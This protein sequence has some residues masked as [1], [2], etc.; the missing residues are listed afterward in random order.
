MVVIEQVAP[1]SIGRELDLEAGDMLLKVNDQPVEDCLDA[2]FWLAEESVLLEIQKANGELWELAVDKEVADDLGLAFE[3]PQPRSCGNQCIFCF[4]HQLPRG[5]RSTLYVMDEDYRFSFLYGA[6]V[7]L[8]NLSEADLQRI[9]NQQLSPL[10]VSV[11]TTNPQLRNRMLHREVAPILPLLQRLLAGGIAM[12]TQVV[13]C[14]EWNDAD[15]LKRTIND[16]HALGEGILSLALVPVGLT[17]QRTGLPRLRVPTA[18][19]AAEVLDLLEPLQETYR[20]ERGTRWVFAADEWYLRAGRDIPDYS[21]Y[22]DF[23]QLENGVGMIADFRHQARRLLARIRSSFHLQLTAV[24]G[25]SFAAELAAFLQKL[26]DKS[27]VQIESVAV[28]SR[29]FGGDVSVAG[30]VAG[31]DIVTQ[32]ENLQLGSALL[33]PDVMLREGTDIFLDN[34]TIAQLAEQLGVPVK[35]V[36]ATPSGLWQ[37]VRWAANLSQKIN[38]SH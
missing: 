32:L 24:T 29:L 5:L 15:E 7:T 17:G 11:H 12:H 4:V 2:R 14:P 21:D 1:D 10:Y 3:H 36:A 9:I 33:V 35:K 28:E 23:P 38:R 16:L 30:L 34:L 37:G 19:E 25:R 26:E 13:V 6:Y 20:N 18:G 22:E 8:S 27:R 31:R